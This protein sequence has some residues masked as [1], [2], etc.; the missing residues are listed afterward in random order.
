MLHCKSGPT[1]LPITTHS[2][3]QPTLRLIRL[4]IRDQSTRPYGD[5]LPLL[6]GRPSLT[7]CTANSEGSL[8]PQGTSLN[9][10][11]Q[12]KKRA[13]PP[14]TLL[15]LPDHLTS[16]PATTLETPSIATLPGIVVLLSLV[17]TV[18]RVSTAVGPFRAERAHHSIVSRSLD[19]FLRSG[20]PPVGLCPREPT[21][22]PPR[23]P[24]SAGP[25]VPRS[26]CL[27]PW[28]LVPPRYHSTSQ[29]KTLTA[30]PSRFPS[31]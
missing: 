22:S 20:L 16:K 6:Q 19:S 12:S 15:L 28:S 5:T 2:H 13:R 9:L 25:Q 31:N 3:P 4:Y 14:G 27:S 18:V 8:D 11:L 30:S 17:A 26:H 7:V 10:R 23:A 21:S 24:E 1:G 29:A